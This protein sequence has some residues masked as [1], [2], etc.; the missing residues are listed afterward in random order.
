MPVAVTN[1]DVGRVE[2]LEQ[3][4]GVLPAGTKRIA[5]LRQ[6]DLTP[7]PRQHEGPP[8]QL[9]EG[10]DRVVDVA[11]HAHGMA[12]PDEAVEYRDRLL[13]LPT[14]TFGKRPRRLRCLPSGLQH[15]EHQL[16]LGVKRLSRR[17]LPVA[18]RLT[19][20]AFLR[21]PLPPTLLGHDLIQ[22]LLADPLQ[23]LPYGGG[24]AMPGR[25]RI[26]DPAATYR[27]DRGDAP[28]HEAVPGSRH[29]RGLQPELREVAA[30]AHDA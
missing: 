19:R 20:W 7:L 18:F 25:S 23:A 10:P 4:L 16:G 9:L 22:P 12:G 3:R 14:E 30:Q 24:R 27:L 26:Q 1:R 2:V 17:D 6:R 5:K 11:A 28:Q 13:R 8:A 29:Q 15:Q 21:A